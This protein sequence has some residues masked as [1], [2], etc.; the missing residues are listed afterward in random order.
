MRKKKEENKKENLI[1]PKVKKTINMGKNA[2]IK[3]NYEN[4]AS[5]A[6]DVSIIGFDTELGSLQHNST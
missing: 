3:P 5:R 6:S 1:E 4:L 2:K